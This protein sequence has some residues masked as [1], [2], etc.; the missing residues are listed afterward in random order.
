MD[1]ASSSDLC[2][3]VRSAKAAQRLPAWR[4]DRQAAESMAK[5]ACCTSG[6][7]GEG[8]QSTCSCHDHMAYC[9]LHSHST[10]CQSLLGPPGTAMSSGAWL[11]ERSSTWERQSPRHPQLTCR[12]RDP[13]RKGGKNSNLGFREVQ[14]VVVQVHEGGD[15]HQCTVIPCIPD[16]QP[17]AQ[18]VDSAIVCA[19]QLASASLTLAAC[20]SG[21]PQVWVAS[22]LLVDPMSGGLPRAA[23]QAE[24]LA[25]TSSLHLVRLDASP[26]SSA[27]RFDGC[28]LD[29][30]MAAPFFLWDL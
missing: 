8:R 24:L 30:C 16:L 21:I 14:T 9:H 17:A 26:H 2:Q 5:D 12:R 6:H 4:Q 18:G 25:L 23:M 7:R 22:L 29:Q 10:P 3:P 13:W 27:H 19:A 1:A 20:S 11:V 28:S 15:A